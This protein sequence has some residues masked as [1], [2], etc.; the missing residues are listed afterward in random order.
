MTSESDDDL[1]NQGG[2][3]PE[4]VIGNLNQDLC[5]EHGTSG[6]MDGFLAAVNM[7]CKESRAGP[8]LVGSI[9]PKADSAMDE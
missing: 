4:G 1:D 5:Q 9:E 7:W 2:V 8:T 3:V 6:S